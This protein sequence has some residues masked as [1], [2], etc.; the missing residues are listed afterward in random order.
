[1]NH[2]TYR[3]LWS[4]ED[5]EFIGLCAE[6][7]SLSWLAATLGEALEGIARVVEEAVRDMRANHK[8]VPEPFSARH[9]SANS[10]CAFRHSAIVCWQWRLQ[11]RA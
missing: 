6:F 7:P 2:Y 1:M 3:I 4:E 8:V 5:G 10:R 9:Y 11:S